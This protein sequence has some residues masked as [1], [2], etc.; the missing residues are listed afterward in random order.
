MSV[1]YDAFLLLQSAAPPSPLRL[2]PAPQTNMF[3]QGLHVGLLCVFYATPIFNR[4]VWW[5]GTSNLISAGE[6]K[7]KDYK[8]TVVQVQN[9]W[10]E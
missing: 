10:I 4:T 8:V 7:K 5:E 6:K 2:S 9:K 3:I 1:F